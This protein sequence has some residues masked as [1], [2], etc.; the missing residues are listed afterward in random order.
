MKQIVVIG[1]GG[2]IPSNVQE[3]A[4]ELG[5]A[6]ARSGAVL[7]TGGRDGVMEAVSKGAKDEGGLTVGILPGF[8]KTANP[9]VDMI[10]VTGMGD[11]RNVINV[12]S[13]DVVI[14]IYG[15]VGTLSEIA[16]G[17]KSGKKVIAIKSSG[18]VAEKM[19]QMTIDGLNV[20]SVE[21]VEEAIRLAFKEP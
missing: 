12:L 10:I 5:R 21:S 20:I 17:L 16:L 8:E 14:A 1:S 4:E 3:M 2:R 18:G 13:A 9:Y 11:A 15:G 19:T 7:I 6:I